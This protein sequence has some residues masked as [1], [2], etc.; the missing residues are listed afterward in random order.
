MDDLYLNVTQGYTD[1]CKITQMQYHSFQPYSNSAFSNN[2]EIR[3]SI[4]NMDAYTLPCES[5]IYIEGNINKPADIQGVD[6]FN[7]TKTGYHFF[8]PK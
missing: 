8:F 4:Q 2:D 3:I 5:Y 1:E 7:F 6:A